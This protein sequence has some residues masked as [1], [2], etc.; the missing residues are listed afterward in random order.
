MGAALFRASKP[1]NAATIALVGI[2]YALTSWV[3]CGATSKVTIGNN[4]G[5]GWINVFYCDNVVDWS[6]W[7]CGNGTYCDSKGDKFNSMFDWTH[8]LI[9]SIANYSTIYASS[10]AIS[11]S[12]LIT[13]SISPL[14][15]SQSGSATS[16]PSVY[17]ADTIPR[18]DAIGI[19]IGIGIPL[20]ILAAGFYALWSHERKKRVRMEKDCLVR[21]VDTLNAPTYSSKGIEY[22]PNG[23]TGQAVEVDNGQG[24]H[25]LAIG[26][27][28]N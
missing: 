25:E 23:Y 2:A 10:P 12:A 20:L 11:S 4:D 6:R 9:Y 15:K 26:G 13:S 19:G 14:A 5:T 16:T 1:T 17:R 28:E 27:A 8:A 18:A 24:A 21:T 3:D 22:Q 7:W